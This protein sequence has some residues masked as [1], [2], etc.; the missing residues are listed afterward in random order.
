MNKPV[1]LGLSILE[2]SKILMR[3]FWYDYVKIM[4][5]YVGL[6]AKTHSY[7]INDGRE[8]KKAKDTKK[9]LI[10][11]LEATQLENKIRYLE[12][13]KI[14][15]DRISCDKRKHK[16]FIRNNKLRLKTH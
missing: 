2:L 8:N 13:N 10:N 4:A 16:E 12:K 14:D 7:L 5:K 6:R 15:I 11:C 3:E 1:H 9:C